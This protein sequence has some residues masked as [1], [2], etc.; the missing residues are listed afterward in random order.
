MSLLQP[1]LYNGTTHVA[2]RR[3]TL[4]C[5]AIGSWIANTGR[6]TILKLALPEKRRTAFMKLLDDLADTRPPF[7]LLMA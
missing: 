1:V 7:Q 2:M 5:I 4:E 3:I 6:H